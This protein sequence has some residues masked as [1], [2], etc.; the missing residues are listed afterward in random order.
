MFVVVVFA[1]AN[2]AGSLIASPAAA[3]GG[4]FGIFGHRLPHPKTWPVAVWVG[5]TFIAW[6]ALSA[7]WSPYISDRAMPGVFRFCTGVPLYGL[8]IFVAS[9]QSEAT[10][11]ILRLV[12]MALI[13][14]SAFIFALEFSADFP[15]YNFFAPDANSGDRVQNVSHGLS[16]ML[17]CLPPVII[18]LLRHGRGGMMIAIAAYIFAIIAAA[19][20]GN[21]AAL[22]TS[23]S[24]VLFMALA[25]K[26]P[27]LMVRLTLLLPIAVVL[28]APVVSI[29]AAEAGA[30]AKAA[31]PFSWEWRAE[32]WGYLSDKI[33]DHPI[34]GNGFDSLRTMKDT[35]EARGFDN[36]P[37][38]SLHAHNFGLQIWVEVGLIGAILA[39]LFFWETS[40]AVR[41]SSWLTPRRAAALCATLLAMVI[42]S[43]LSY[44]SWQDWWWGAIAFA[45]AFCT[46]IPDETREGV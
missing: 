6:C 42:F 5:L 37:Y 28:L 41:G 33:V 13:P 2:H 34:A 19:Y 10:K 46:L 38:V 21:A 9:K 29:I 3:I 16:V 15:V 44:S 17:M 20:S 39:A 14:I 12:I 1:L 8:M 26:F 40:A 22:I 11:R 43:S 45:L 23:A 31:L 32:T 4:L 18:L 35:F 24:L 36:L 25:V 27:K 30:D 7:L